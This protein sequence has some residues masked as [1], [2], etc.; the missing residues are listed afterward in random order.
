MARSGLTH[1]MS[2]TKAILAEGLALGRAVLLGPPSL[3]LRHNSGRPFL[4]NRWSDFIS[5]ERS[6]FR[7]VEG[8]TTVCQGVLSSCVADVSDA[9]L[10]AL[11]EKPHENI[12]YHDGA[13]TDAQNAKPGLLQRRPAPRDRNRIKDTI[14]LF[15]K[16]PNMT[17][18]I[19]RHRLV[20][21]FAASDKILGAV[22][23]VRDRVRA[24]SRTGAA[25][26]ARRRAD[27]VP[28]RPGRPTYFKT[29]T[30][31]RPTLQK[32]CS[33]GR[34]TDRRCTAAAATRSN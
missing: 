21:N 18:F 22:P 14:N 23:L 6:T 20:A 15:R 11:L 31:R 17:S 29:T 33:Y 16:L 5:F 19:G 1:Q 10:G 9:Q 7:I 12:R 25:V 13:V 8:R 28:A 34:E 2:N 26:V 24:L 27:I 32:R 4:F 30:V 3:S